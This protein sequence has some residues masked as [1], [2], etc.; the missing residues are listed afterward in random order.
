MEMGR[1]RPYPHESWYETAGYYFFFGHFYAAGVITQLPLEEQAH[2]WRLLA[3]VLLVCQQADGSWWDYPLYGYGK[4]YGTA[5][6]LLAL[7][8]AS[9]TLAH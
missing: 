5:Y 3:R 4:A 9:R 1:N 2:Y 8:P 6:A 7:A